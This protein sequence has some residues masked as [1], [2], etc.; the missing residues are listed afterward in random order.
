[1]V[2]IFLRSSS[3]CIVRTFSVKVLILDKEVP[4]RVL[5]GE[6]EEKYLAKA[7]EEM[8]NIRQK[9]NKGKRSGKKGKIARSDN[10]K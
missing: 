5:E 2:T 3:F 9:Y 7:K 1:M 4:C 8:A 6:E 10:C